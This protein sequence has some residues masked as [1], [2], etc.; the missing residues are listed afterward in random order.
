M[1][2][3]LGVKFLAD[4]KLFKTMWR[5]HQQRR[6]RQ[7]V[8]TRRPRALAWIARHEW[9]LLDESATS[10]ALAFEQVD[11]VNLLLVLPITY[12]LTK[13]SPKKIEQNKGG[14]NIVRLH[15]KN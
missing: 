14:N 3:C 5:R 4:M 7:A 6:P 11:L 15:V 13:I 10:A 12:I 8:W 9:L 1:H 2:A